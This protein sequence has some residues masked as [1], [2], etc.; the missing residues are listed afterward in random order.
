MEIAL[1]PTKGNTIQIGSVF[2]TEY[3]TAYVETL[4]DGTAIVTN[5]ITTVFK[6]V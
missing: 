1:N 3:D 6:D 4:E 5:V 2:F